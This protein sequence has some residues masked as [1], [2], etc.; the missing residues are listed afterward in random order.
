MNLPMSV[1]FLACLCLFLI[2]EMNRR[3]NV[4]LLKNN[5]LL[6]NK[7]KALT[8]EL[9]E[10]GKLKS[11]MLLR[12]GS[13]LRKPLESVRGTA[14]ELSRSPEKSQGVKEQLA[15]L[16]NEITEIENF[17]DI[18]KELAFLEK[19]DLLGSSQFP[20]E[21]G[22]S[23]LSLDNLLFDTL[24]EWNDEFSS[25]GVSLAISIDENVMVTGSRHYLKHALENI[26]S[27]ISR[28]TVSGS[29]VHIVLFNDETSVR[30]K[31]AYKG[32]PAKTVKQSAFGV[33][34]ARQII[35]IHDGWLAGDSK[36]GQYM[37]ELPSLNQKMESRT[38]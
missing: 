13:S 24:S 12:I 3:K 33:E 22:S 4:E 30:M 32:E 16:T 21:D 26:L 31:I 36:T 6:K 37:M 8:K 10:L 1:I 20:D 38:K 5:K 34:L 35:S 29:L 28:I 25:R 15:R 14:I 2:L 23:S 18:M 7:L 17:L 9:N 11:D 27:E 19:M